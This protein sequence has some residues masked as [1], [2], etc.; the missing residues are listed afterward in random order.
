MDH[1]FIHIEADGKCQSPVH[2]LYE[3]KLSTEIKKAQCERVSFSFIYQLYLGTL[4][5]TV[6]WEK[7]SQ[8]VL[9]GTAATW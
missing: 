8:L 6:A 7:A 3:S 5:R 9:R 2:I 4:L 1:D